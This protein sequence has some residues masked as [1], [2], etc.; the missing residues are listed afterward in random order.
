MI[1]LIT[2]DQPL[3]YNAG[4]SR[5]VVEMIRDNAAFVDSPNN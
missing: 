4:I 3:F 1:L 5:E 2:I